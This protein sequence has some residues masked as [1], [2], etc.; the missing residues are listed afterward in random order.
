MVKTPSVRH[1]KSRNDPVTIDLEPSK[2][3]S[4][5][6][7]TAKPDVTSATDAK[8]AASAPAGSAGSAGTQGSDK[9]EAAKEAASSATADKPSV[10]QPSSSAAEKKAGSTFSTASAGTPSYSPPSSG[11]TAGAKPSD[12][13]A[14]E[15]PRA[16]QSAGNPPPQVPKRS[17]FSALAAGIIGGFVVLAGAGALQYGGLLPSLSAAGSNSAELESL[18]SEII[19]LRTELADVKTGND[20]TT[21]A[22]SVSELQ[23]RVDTLTSDI[24]AIKSSV[25]SSASGG[26]AGIAA[27]D[28]KIAELQTQLSQLSQNAV[29][30]PVDLAPLSERVAVL[31]ASVKAATDASATDETRL[32]TLEQTVEGLTSK[33][34]AQAN[35]PKIALSIAASA[36]KTAIDRG[37]PF[38]AEIETLAA[39]SPDVPQLAT[40]RNYAEAGV[41][42]REDLLAE[43]APAADAMIASSRPVDPNANYFNQLLDS[44]ASLVTVRPVGSVEGTGVPET[45]AR[46]E[47]AVKAG[48]LEAAL[49]EYETLPDTAKAAGRAFADRV[50][51][52][53]D[54][55]TLADQAIA[56][57]M[58][59]V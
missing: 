37:Q 52:R 53:L 34:E 17:G 8:K 36:L 32:A 22:N 23:T 4:G 57:A 20:T 10:D 16:T 56:E 48:D 50:K 31:E 43:M 9:G 38:T 5:K 54:V 21:T 18:R 7:E 12:K 11:N 47:V 55:E 29:T 2:I 39:I 13:K 44:A 14:E 41:A 46:M 33:M 35:Q 58:R 28:G 1:S 49:A 30:E 51:A 24:A 15:K 3:P 59:T 27:L 42:T 6:P 40:L 25:E 26:D 19:A 45:V